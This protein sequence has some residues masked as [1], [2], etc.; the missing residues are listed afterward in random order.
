MLSTEVD[1]VQDEFDRRCFP[2]QGGDGMEAV[3]AGEQ[4]G[5]NASTSSVSVV[6][7]ALTWGTV[8]RTRLEAVL[9]SAEAALPDLAGWSRVASTAQNWCACNQAIK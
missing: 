5:D 8:T 7:T 1:T 9:A 3:L 6:V 2:L 4:Q